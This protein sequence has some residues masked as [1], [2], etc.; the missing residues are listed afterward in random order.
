VEGLESLA[1]GDHGIAVGVVQRVVEINKQIFIFHIIPDNTSLFCAKVSIFLLNN[2]DNSK[3]V[4]PLLR[5]SEGSIV[6]RE[7]T[8][9]NR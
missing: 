4:V 5:K 3:K 6:L 9:R 7:K 8:A 1:E 2:K